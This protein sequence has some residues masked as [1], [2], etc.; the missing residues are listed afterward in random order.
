[1]RYEVEIHTKEDVKAALL[2]AKKV[3]ENAGFSK[4]EEQQLLVSV[5]ELT[6]NIIKHSGSSGRFICY[7]NER[8][9]HLEIE[10]SGKG[11]TDLPRVLKESHPPSS[12]GLGL[13]LRGAKRIMDKFSIMS[14]PDEGVKIYALKKVKRPLLGAL[15]QLAIVDFSFFLF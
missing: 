2:C 11:I 5:S 4:F 15:I 9:I 3:A 14:S 7:S 13:G 10:D 12:R 8:G 6:H 1:M